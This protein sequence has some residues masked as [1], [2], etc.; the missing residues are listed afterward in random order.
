[1][2]AALQQELCFSGPDLEEADNRRLGRQLVAVRELMLD[3]AWRSLAD[4]AARVAGSEA[5][6]SARLRDLRKPGFGGYLVERRRAAAWD[7]APCAIIR[8]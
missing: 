8:A 1:M 7:D 5:G 6:I 3:G 4:I 2:S